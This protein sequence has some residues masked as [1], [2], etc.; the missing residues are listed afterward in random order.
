MDMVLKTTTD[1]FVFAFKIDK[2]AQEALDQIIDRAYH[3][4]FQL[5]T[6]PI[7]LIGANFDTK[8]RK[9]S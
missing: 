8:S 5:D 3:T 9:L 4:Q 6:Q 7:T 1:T 2:A